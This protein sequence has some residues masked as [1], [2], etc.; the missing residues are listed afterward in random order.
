MVFNNV[1][2]DIKE[3]D[4]SILKIYTHQRYILWCPAYVFLTSCAK[5][6]HI[7][8]FG[9]QKSLIHVKLMEQYWEFFVFTKKKNYFIDHFLVAKVMFSNQQIHRL[10][11][12][13]IL[14]ALLLLL[15][16]L[17]RAGTLLEY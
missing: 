3:M 1:E 11:S 8:F 10:L 15:F 16:A 9:Q 6:I 4:D 14:L 13:V 2:L 7:S 5:F 17:Q 12:M